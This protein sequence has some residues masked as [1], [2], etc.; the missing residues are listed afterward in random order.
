MP[1]WIPTEIPSLREVSTEY[2]KKSIL[3]VMRSVKEN[4]IYALKNMWSNNYISC[5]K[6]NY[7]VWEDD[8]AE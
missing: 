4:I 1:F 3:R 6:Y 8:N 5:E 7:C 2:F